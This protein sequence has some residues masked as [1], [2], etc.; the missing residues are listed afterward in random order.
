MEEAQKAM[1]QAQEQYYEAKKR[2]NPN[3]AAF[4]AAYTK[5]QETF[6]RHAKIIQEAQAQH[7]KTLQDANQETVNSP[8]FL[9]TTSPDEEPAQKRIKE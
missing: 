1:Q 8:T 6:R 7:E 2:G 3:M 9:H 4:S 5:A